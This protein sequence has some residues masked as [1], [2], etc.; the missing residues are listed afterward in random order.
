MSKGLAL[1]VLETF[2]FRNARWVKRDPAE[3]NIISLRALEQEGLLA[4]LGY[5]S[6]EITPLGRLYCALQAAP[7]GIL[8]EDRDVYLHGAFCDIP[9]YVLQKTVYE[10]HNKKLAI[11]A[12]DGTIK[13]TD[14]DPL[15]LFE[16]YAK[17][18]Q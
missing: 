3:I 12:G 2:K 6:C 5:N 16:Y 18:A 8:M 17:K 11:V 9:M 4:I 14:T 15:P 13:Q 7:D 1:S 10:L